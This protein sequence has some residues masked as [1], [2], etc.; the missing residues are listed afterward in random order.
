[1][2][3][4]SSTGPEMMPG[5]KSSGF[6]VVVTGEAVVVG[7]AVMVGEAAEV[8][9]AGE[10]EGKVEVVEEA[11]EVE[12]GEA[13]SRLALICAWSRWMGIIMMSPLLALT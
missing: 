1:M 11:V 10:V 12:V 3:E 2:G 9:V 5:A 4:A 8:R 7:E 13:A 6:E